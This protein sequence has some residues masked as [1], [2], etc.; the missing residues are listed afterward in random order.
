MIGKERHMYPGNNTPLGFF[1]YYQYILG[2]READK[3]ICI[4][5]MVLALYGNFKNI[6]NRQ[7]KLKITVPLISKENNIC[8]SI[9]E[10]GDQGIRLTSKEID[11]SEDMDAKRLA[12]GTH[13]PHFLLRPEDIGTSLDREKFI[14]F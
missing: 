10:I 5:E 2:Q 14:K 4:K 7:E 3:I 6:E 11:L 9:M 12:V 8:D 13:M 1:S